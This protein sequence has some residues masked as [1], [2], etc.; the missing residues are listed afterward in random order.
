MPK[1]PVLPKRRKRAGRQPGPPKP[2]PGNLSAEAA[3]ADLSKLLDARE[4][5]TI[6]DANAFIQRVLASHDGRLP[7]PAPKTPLDRAQELIYQAHE[8]TPPK[9][10][11]ALAHQAL[12][13]T[14]DCADAYLLLAELDPSPTRKFD[15]LE[16]AVAAGERA[17]GPE[18]FERWHGHFWGRIEMRPYMRALGGL[19]ELCWMLGNRPRA[20][21]LYAR[22]L[23][24]NQ[25]DNQGIRY[26]LATCLL[27]ERT[28][29][30]HAALKK[31]L[32]DFPNDAAATWAYSRA[33]LA[34]QEHDGPTPNATRALR[35]ALKANK[36]VPGILLGDQPMPLALPRFI[37]FGDESEAIEYVTFAVRAW[38][39]TPG[40][41]AWLRDT[42]RG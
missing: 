33:L 9:R 32:S 15:F 35:K 36:H 26:M 12:E 11:A 10:R 38:T 30:A 1:T 7:E 39:Q 24:L 34:F 29:E 18:A 23:E 20:R 37:G 3:I 31:L 28:A 19:A 14:P 41:I 5:D 42:I 21:A 25:S 13:I 16:Q 2:M 22:M 40:S 8:A 17:I 6:D 4:F 27:E